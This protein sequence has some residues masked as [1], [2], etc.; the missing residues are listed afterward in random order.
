MGVSNDRTAVLMG[1]LN[2][3]RFLLPQLF[4]IVHQTVWSWSLWVSDDGSEDGTLALLQGYQASIGTDRLHILGG[5]RQ[6]F[7]RNFL[8]LV[9]NPTIRADYFAFADQDD[10]W[11]P[12]KLEQATAVLKSY[13]VNRPALYCSR[14][15]VIDDSGVEQGQSLLERAKPSF[16]NALIQNIASGNTMV[17]NAAARDLLMKA[18]PDVDVFA[19]DWW[20]YLAVMAVGGIAIFDPVP[21]VQYRQH[22]DNQV[23][24]TL[25]VPQLIRRTQLDRNGHLR[26]TFRRNIAALDRIRTQMTQENLYLLSKADHLWHG[27]ALCRGLAFMRLPFKRQTFLGNASLALAVLLGRI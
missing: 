5:P 15:L 24:A 8:S 17:F 1:T 11:L 10:V 27:N 21:R 12:D 9:C 2:G 6:G 14:T 23:G 19:H 16:G 7:V 4:S 22:P 26:S 25:K 20:V 3:R 18:G 13:P